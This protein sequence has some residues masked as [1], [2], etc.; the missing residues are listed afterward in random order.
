MG[1]PTEAETEAWIRE[2]LL[3]SLRWIAA[4]PDAQ[5]VP[6]KDANGRWRMGIDEIAL[7]LE[8][9]WVVIEAN[10]YFDEETRARIAEIDAMFGSISGM[11]NEAHWTEE[12]IA[13]DAVWVRAREKAR[14]LLA[15]LGESRD[16]E[17]LTGHV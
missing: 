11:E 10:T 6:L 7:T 9:V 8:D 4:E 12:A 17:H 13:S 16:D 3:W 1:R 15:T 2:R 14:T 5:L